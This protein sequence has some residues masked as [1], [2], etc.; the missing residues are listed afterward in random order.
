VETL[1]SREEES[2]RELIGIETDTFRLKWPLSTLCLL[3]KLQRK[4]GVPPSDATELDKLYR[5]LIE[6]DPLRRGFYSDA[7]SL[8]SV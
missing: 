1:F 6:I 8:D 5:Q 7:A 4:I 3:L 2:C